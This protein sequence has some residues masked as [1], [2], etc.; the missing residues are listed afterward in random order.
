MELT[1]EQKREFAH[2]GVLKLP[3][4]V[5]PELVARARRAINANLGQKGM[6]PAELT[7]YRAQSY[8]PGL[9]GD[10]VIT[11]LYNVTPIPTV[12]GS[13]IGVGKTRPVNGGQIAL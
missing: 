5:P 8:C 9:G 11:D 7:K 3:G 13:L 6:D 12:V 4:I 2:R 10:P 1:D